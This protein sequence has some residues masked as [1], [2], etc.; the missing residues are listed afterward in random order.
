MYAAVCML[1]FLV[2]ICSISIFLIIAVFVGHHCHQPGCNIGQEGPEMAQEGW[3]TRRLLFAI[4]N[5]FT[6]DK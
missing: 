1:M 5:S 2:T 3:Q 4:G 6:L